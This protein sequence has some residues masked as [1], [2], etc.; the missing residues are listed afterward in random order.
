LCFEPAGVTLFFVV[1]HFIASSSTDSI[2]LHQFSTSK[3]SLPRRPRQQTPC[4]RRRRLSRSENQD[5]NSAP[6]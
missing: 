2:L 1:L 6:E 4:R 5:S 3:F